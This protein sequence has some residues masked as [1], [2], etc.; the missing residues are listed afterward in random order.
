DRPGRGEDLHY[1]MEIEVEDSLRGI[2]LV[3]DVARLEPCVA[4]SAT[5]GAHGRQVELCAACEGR[6]VRILEGP[7]RPVAG[8]CQACRG[9]GWQLPERCVACGGGGTVTGTAR[10][11]VR[12]PPGVGPRAQVRVVGVGTGGAAAASP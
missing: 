4:C 6:P 10:I 11:P 12:I 7:G 1:A 8:R 3:L 9:T 2:R 5:G